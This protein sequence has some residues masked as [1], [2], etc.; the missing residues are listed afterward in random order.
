L[1]DLAALLGPPPPLR[2]PVLLR[3]VPRRL[4]QLARQPPRRPAPAPLWLL[5]LLVP[6][7]QP[8]LLRC[9]QW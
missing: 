9:W 2:R 6:L 7:L 5:A 1:E 8:L 4:P 3:P